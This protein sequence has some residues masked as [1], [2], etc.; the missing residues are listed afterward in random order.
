M[1]STKAS[2]VN[3]ETIWS[4]FLLLFFASLFFP[5]GQAIRYFFLG[6]FVLSSIFIIKEKKYK[7]DLL[8]L[9]NPFLYIFI[10]LAYLVISFLLSDQLDGARALRIRLPL[11]LFPLVF[12]FIRINRDKRDGL[13]LKFAIITTIFCFTS[14]NYAI[15]Q[16]IKKDDNAWLYND[17][18][19]YFINQQSIYTSLLVN[20]SIYVFAFFLIKKYHV[21]KHKFLLILTIAFL[22]IISYLLAS[23]IMMFQLYFTILCLFIYIIFKQKKWFLGLA[24]LCGLLISVV[25]VYIFFPKTLNRFKELTITSYQYNNTAAES[26]YGGVLTKEQWNGANFRL[27]AWKCGWELFTHHPVTGVGLGDKA[28]TLNQLYKEKEFHFAIETGKNVHNNYLDIL[29]SMGII[30]LLLFLLGWLFLPLIQFLKQKD[31][32]AIIITIT[33]ACAMI[34][35]VYF[36]RSLG[37]VLF[38]FFIPFLLSGTQTTLSKNS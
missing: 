21:I 30:G 26:H 22:F 10:F 35:E 15:F 32:L 31:I 20:I 7:P 3:K 2:L 5:F 37:V 33:F 23:R 19:S 38:G 1:F 13:L 27:A 18:L 16:A 36:D 6:A 25:T 9:S 29:Y 8:K 28:T 24:L 34:T 12:L 4:G 14:L 17:A 11:F